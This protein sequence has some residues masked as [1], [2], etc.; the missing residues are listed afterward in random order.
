M[1]TTQEIDRARPLSANAGEASGN[2]LNVKKQPSG[3]FVD[4]FAAHWPEYSME[5]G[6]LGMFMISAC[7]FTVIFQLPS[8]PI[9]QAIPSAFLR[10]ALTGI[11]M[12]LTAIALIYSPWGQRSGAHINPSITLTFYRLGKIRRPD[13]VFYV[14][15]Q[16]IGASIGVTIAALAL[17]SRVAH[18]NVRFAAT[19][20]GDMGE[21]LAV[22][23]EF[24][25]SFLLMSAVLYISNHP[26]LGRFTGL[27]AGLLVATYITIESPYSGMSMNPART[28][29]SALPSGIWHGFWIYLIVP[30]VAMLSAAEWLLWKRGSGSIR[31][32]KLY[33]SP[34]RNC[35]FCGMEGSN[36]E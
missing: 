12:G 15:F 30:P 6:L 17:G 32:C 1:A 22:I 14:L 11:A 34:K 3:G 13:A 20:P 28:F 5:A 25:I 19:Y 33:H 27:F 9:N 2:G 23:G 26:H 10:R 18:P 4:S 24:I 8:S 21:V 31:C 29:G 7:V 35:I 36:H 16:V